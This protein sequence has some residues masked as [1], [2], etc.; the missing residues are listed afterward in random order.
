MGRISRML[1]LGAVMVGV[2]TLAA[3]GTAFGKTKQIKFTNNSSEDATDLHVEFQRGSLE[4]TELDP[5]DSFKTNDADDSRSTVNFAAG[6][7]GQGV[8]ASNSVVITFK[9]SGSDPK[10]KSAWWTNG[11]TLTP[12]GKH[13]K[14]QPGTGD[15]I[16]DGE[17]LAGDILLSW[18]GGRAAGDGVYMVLIDAQPRQFDTFPGDTGETVSARFSQFVQEWEFGSVLAEAPGMVQCTG[19]SYFNDLPNIQ[20]DVLQQDSQL[21]MFVDECAMQLDVFNLVAGERAEFTIT[22]SHEGQVVAIV[23]SLKPGYTG[24]NGV[25]GYCGSL[26]LQG[27][28]PNNLIGQG[29]IVG[30]QYTK[31][32]PIPQ[33]AGGLELM[34]QG[35]LRDLCP[36]SCESNVVSQVIQK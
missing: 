18:S 4:V 24:V 8:K 35:I 16:P 19:Y 32:V 12:Q 30:G 13:D 26:G 2:S 1:V 10:V 33:N 21:E 27:V 23:Y 11:N 31:F 9:Y 7:T 14:G 6:L 3:T 5:A 22:D 17:L 20:I 36:G 25:A 15:Y 28:T 34:T 29:P